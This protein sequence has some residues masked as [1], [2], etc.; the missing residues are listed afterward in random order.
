MLKVRAYSKIKS[1]KHLVKYVVLLCCIV[2]S[3]CKFIL[4]FNSH[5]ENGQSIVSTSRM[6]P[7]LNYT[8]TTNYSYNWIDASEGDLLP[9]GYNG[10]S[11]IELP[12]DFF[13]YDRNFSAIFLSCNGYLSFVASSPYEDISYNRFPSKDHPYT[14][15]PFWT[16]LEDINDREIYVQNFTDYW[17]AEWR[18]MYYYTNDSVG[19]FEVILYK[20]GEIAFN[21]DLLLVDSYYTCGLNFG[22]DE[23]YYNLFQDLNENLS[24]FALHFTQ[25]QPEHDIAVTLDLPI[26]P[27]TDNTYQINAT[28]WNLGINDES[29]IDFIL[30]LNDVILNSTIISSLLSNKTKTISYE[31]A[32]TSPGVYNF[33]AVSSSVLNESILSNNFVSYLFPVNALKNYTMY[34]NY[35]YNWIDASNANQIILSDDGYRSFQLPFMFNFYNQ[36]FT[37]VYVSANGY[38][39]FTDSSPSNWGNVVFPTDFSQWTYMIAPFWD[40][41]NPETGGKIYTQTS[42]NYCV[43]EWRNICYG[44]G[45]LVGSFEVVLFKSG[46]I[47]FNYDYISST[48]GNPTCGLNLGVNQSYYSTY[49]GLTDSIDDF[50]ILFTQTELDHEIVVSLD[51]PYIANSGGIYMINASV[52]NFGKYDES[53]VELYLYIDNVRVNSTSIGNFTKNSTETITFEWLAIELKELNFT[54]YSNTIIDEINTL[55]NKITKYLTVT[56]IRNYDVISNS[57]YFWIDAS[58]GMKLPISRHGGYFKLHLPFDFYFYNQSFSEIYVS[59]HGYLSFTDSTP[60]EFSNRPFPSNWANHQYMIA[61]LWSDYDIS[62]GGQ[63]FVQNFS[64]Y[65]VVEWYNIYICDYFDIIGGTFEVILYKTGDI[66]FSYYDIN[67]LRNGY[68]CGLNLGLDQKFYS[69][70]TGL[71]TWTNR[72]SLYFTQNNYN[73]PDSPNLHSINPGVDQD[74][75]ITLNW[76][77]D[78]N[79]LFY[80][81]YRNTEPITNLNSRWLI[82]CMNFDTSFIDIVRTNQIYYYVIVAV[83]GTGISNPSNCESVSVEL[84]PPPNPVLENIGI[85]PNDPSFINLTWSNIL[86]ATSYNIYRDIQPIDTPNLAQLVKSVSENSTT[87]VLPSTG[88]YYY[89]ITAVNEAGESTPSNCISITLNTIPTKKWTILIYI[90]ADNNLER[91]GIE[92]INEMEM[93]GSDNNINIVVQIDR[94]IGYDS[95]NGDWTDTRRGIILKDSDETQI[96]STLTSLGEL[97]MANG[98]TLVD[99]ITWGQERCPAENYALIL[100]DHGTGVMNNL[101]EGGVCNDVNN[102]GDYL[103]YAEIKSAIIGKEIDILG[104]DACLMASVEFYYALQNHTDIFIGAEGFEPGEGWPYDVFLNWLKSN[105]DTNSTQFSRTIVDNYITSLYQLGREGTLSSVN[106]SNINEIMTT[107]S[108]YITALTEKMNIYRNIIS[109]VRNSIKTYYYQPYI[110]LYEFIYKLNSS[111]PEFTELA[112]TVLNAISTGVVN[113]RYRGNSYYDS[114]GLSIYFPSTYDGFSYIYCNLPWSLD[115]YWDE[116]LI[117]YYNVINPNPNDPDDD[118]DSYEKTTISGYNAFL[119]ISMIGISIVYLVLRKKYIKTKKL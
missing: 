34:T 50:S 38:L 28:V 29:D 24:N 73:P 17:V 109:S 12:F 111:I 71:S 63:I 52:Y 103:T 48:L 13:F 107:F 80:N 105:P 19:S 15:A 88:T 40:D 35:A 83:N 4:N 119:L 100:W 75:I 116:F 42:D 47:L 41:L 8:M 5:K 51:T 49:D 33:T 27:K 70:F 115:G 76:N 65:W 78:D 61:P 67:S 23:L 82:K 98:Q 79:V 26:N 1:K 118:P 32:P 106:S 91:Y 95:T 108:N 39:S 101:V 30:Y 6:I 11:K 84:I 56:D 45:T 86:S 94:R 113:A 2:I 102:E 57:P 37:K 14:I 74:G 114:N 43:I 62:K 92:D 25:S 89:V 54:V 66:V 60:S 81:I 22:L 93:V 7:P 87:D 64:D 59:A 90:A 18:N 72:Y 99:F 68:T 117:K 112:N 58:K 97:N 55:N 21:Y 9:L 44:G 36:T 77:S 46:D 104:F 3:N 85:D 110:D 16:W 10:Y 69:V 31:W 96:E 20:T 53:N